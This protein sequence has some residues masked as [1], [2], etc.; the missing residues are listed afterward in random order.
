MRSPLADHTIAVT[1][2]AGAVGSV[3][4]RR[5]A[6]AGARVRAMVHRSPVDAPAG[7]LQIPAD[8]AAP[9]SLRTLV[10]GC[11][12]VIHCAAELSYDAAACRATNVDGVA[13]LLDAM[14]AAGRPR[15]VHL[16][17]VSVYDARTRLDFDED[18][19]VWPEPLDPYGYTKAEGERLV[20]ESGLDA[21]ILRPVLILSAHPRSYWGPLACERARASAQSILPLAD[22]PYVHVDN[23]V[24][25]IVL[26]A[27]RA[28]AIGRTYD[29]IDGAGDVQQ[30]LAAIYGAIGRPAPPVPASAPRVTY[31]G[32]RIRSELGYAPADRWA[33]ALAE[34]SAAGSGR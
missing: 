32:Q 3:V 33:Q 16:S 5:L 12:L 9:A 6:A 17:T 20:R 10:D 11:D 24:D 28:E 8:L 19:P 7:V 21:T 22:V 1:G 25:A 27:T 4:V 15:L 2:A 23:L 30:Y 18:S 14:R 31:A 34:L 29:V 13:R 26:A